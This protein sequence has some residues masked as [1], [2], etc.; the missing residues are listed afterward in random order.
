MDPEIKPADP[1][2]AAPPAD[3]KAPAAPVPSPAESTDDTE[4]MSLAEARKL[5]QEANSLRA[6]LAALE[7]SQKAAEDAKLSEL[8]RATKRAA[9]LE[10]AL[11]AQQ[12]T[13][14]TLALRASLADEAGKLGVTNLA[15]LLK[16]VRDD[17]EWD[18]ATGEPTNL[19]KLVKQ[20]LA[21]VPGLAGAAPAPPVQGGGPTNP[22]R[23][24]AQRLTREM[25]AAMPRS[26]LT[27][28]RAEIDA[29]LAANQ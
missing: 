9:E 12:A 18:E 5:R 23:P 22:A 7:K 13:N 19:A 2:P 17:V 20:A 1:A 26:E 28:R 14:R 6:R 8:D 24:P 10:A 29:W 15:A 16:L 4:Q 21:D 3:D 11:A 27:A 25:I